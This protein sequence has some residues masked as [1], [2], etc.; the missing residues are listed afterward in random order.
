LAYSINNNL[1]TITGRGTC[2][3][4]EIRIPSNIEG[5][6]VTTLASLAFSGDTV[7]TKIVLPD[8][9]QT[10]EAGCF[11]YTSLTEL[12]IPANVNSI[13]YSSLS[14]CSNLTSVTVDPLNLTYYSSGNCIISRFNKT[15]TSG[16]GA[17]VIPNDGSVTALAPSSFKRT[18]LR[19]VTIP[20]GI[21]EIPDSCFY[22]CATLTAVTIPNSVTRIGE[23][24]F[25]HCKAIS[26]V[27]YE[28]SEADWAKIQR[29][30][31]GMIP[32][33]AKIVYGAATP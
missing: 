17:S 26:T 28:G 2:K 5:L 11:S 22:D 14:N 16:C 32:S 9:L 7:L 33:S 27:Y 29:P 23:D 4:A 6:P 10:L 3:D 1:V 31:N 30:E 18:N 15:V 24:A 19:E 8:T 13:Y 25:Y 21:T 12:Y 20:N